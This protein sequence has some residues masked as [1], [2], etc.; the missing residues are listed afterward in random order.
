VIKRQLKRRA[1]IE[2]VIGHCKEEHRMGRNFLA[3]AQGDAINQAVTSGLARA[4]GASLDRSRAMPSADL[5][6]IDLPF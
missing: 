5:Y 4:S 6:L 2:P 3:H 1:A